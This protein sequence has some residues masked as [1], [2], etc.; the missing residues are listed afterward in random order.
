MFWPKL[1]TIAR[2]YSIASYERG[3][4]KHGANIKKFVDDLKKSRWMTPEKKAELEAFYAQ[5]KGKFD[6]RINLLRKQVHKNDLALVKRSM[7]ALDIVMKEVGKIEWDYALQNTNKPNTAIQPPKNSNVTTSSPSLSNNGSNTITMGDSGIKTEY[8]FKVK[9]S[10]PVVGIKDFTY[11]NGDQV[12]CVANQKGQ[13]I[14]TTSGFQYT[15]KFSDRHPQAPDSVQLIAESKLGSHKAAKLNLS[16][17]SLNGN[18]SGPFKFNFPLALQYVPG[19]RDTADSDGHFTYQ[20]L[21]K[22]HQAEKTVM[23]SPL[24]YMN[25]AMTPGGK[26]EA[27]RRKYPECSGSINIEYTT[28]CDPASSTSSSVKNKDKHLCLARCK[29]NFRCSNM[30]ETGPIK[31]FNPVGDPDAAKRLATS[32]TGNF[33]VPLYYLKANGEKYWRGNK[34]SRAYQPKDLPF[35]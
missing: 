1:Q 9:V 20:V 30:W 26:M 21:N 35:K 28:Q 31:I 14:P 27:E 5:T 24:Y 19:G 25:K 3:N 15:R 29:G 7:P 18:A 17:T 22:W 2:G 11:H 33:D 16:V 10:G 12:Y 8:G 34:V 32:I 4:A 6:W 23:S 13:N